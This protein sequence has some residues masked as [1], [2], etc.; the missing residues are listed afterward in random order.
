MKKYTRCRINPNEDVI[1][2]VLNGKITKQYQKVENGGSV[3]NTTD[4]ITETVFANWISC[5]I[6]QLKRSRV[7]LLEIFQDS[8]RRK[9]TNTVIHT[10]L[11]FSSR[12]RTAIEN[13]TAIA[14]FDAALKG[15][16]LAYYGVVTNKTNEF[17]SAFKESTNM[18]HGSKSDVGEGRAFLALMTQI[19]KC[20]DEDTKGAIQILTD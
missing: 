6:R 2:I 20:L 14:C 18:W 13:R 10:T 12:I 9:S 17:E 5:S 19:V 8:Q 16:I 11:Q 7:K 15:K 4:K 3:F 1:I